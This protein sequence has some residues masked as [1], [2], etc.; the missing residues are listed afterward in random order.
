M[1]T[2]PWSRRG[3]LGAAVSATLLAPLLSAGPAHAA[4]E[5][6]DTL[7]L[8]WRE[9]LLG[10]GIDAVDPLFASRLT[11]LGT[12]AAGHRS[13]MAPSSA[14]LWPDLPYDSFS[15]DP[16]SST[17][18]RLK[19]MALAWSQPGT[20]LTGDASLAADIVAGLDHV[21]DNLYNASFTLPSVN[22]WWNAQIGSAQA[23]LDVC[24]LMYDKLSAAQIANYCA[25]IDHFLPESEL[26]PDSVHGATGAN[27]VDF[28]RVYALRGVVGKTPERITRARDALSVIFPYVTSGNGFYADGSF[29]EHS[30]IPYTGSYGAALISGMAWIFALLKGSTW[31]VTDAKKQLILDS[32]EDSFAPFL[33]NGVLMD[34]VSGR[35][36]S[37]GLSAT[38]TNGFASSDHVRGQSVMA[39]IL[40]LGMGASATE[41]ARWKG[42]VKGW[43]QRDYYLT[44]EQNSS[45][46][47][48]SFSRLRA[49]REDAAVA[50]VAEPTGHRLFA[51]MDRATHRRPGWAA[52][53]SMCSSD[54]AFYEFG[55]QENKRGWNTS[56]GMLY[57]WKDRTLGQFSDAFWPT[58]DPYRLPGT[59]VSRKALADGAGGDFGAPKPT[60]TWAG[61]ATDGTYAAIGMD[62]R[63]LQ[64][65]LGG[66]K[67]WFFLDDAIVCLGAGIGCTDGTGVESIVE[68]R[69]LGASGTHTLTVDGTAQ[70]ATQGWSATL[71]GAKWATLA[72]MGG[73]V[74][75]GG[76]TVK[77]QRAERT[78]AWSDVNGGGS[79]TAL[80]RRYLSLW[81]DHGTDP[82]GG[83]YA[84]I[85]MPGA[86]P[87]ATAARATDTNWL[88]V[89]A[90]S[91]NQQGIRVPSLGYTAVNFYGTGTVDKLISN[92]PASV[93]TR[94]SG[95]T[96]TLR[97]ANP[98]KTATS[99]DITWNRPVA[100]VLSKDPS[101]T[102]LSTGASLQLRIDTSAKTGATHTVT[103]TLA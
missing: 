15:G 77:A 22:W 32:V 9:L 82:S 91:G 40:M 58:V 8:R 74:F 61:G 57:W 71:T 59:T 35:A 88:T 47:L 97:V 78:G 3:F 39:A 79:T 20:G 60:S 67:S 44:L 29:V 96:A 25:A 19:T 6:Y 5:A 89:L 55:N 51:A 102:V 73:Y 14:A 84:Y 70:P 62:I 37:R 18:N 81:F 24:V 85:L 28:A 75:P 45:L 52:T 93:M 64:S 68:N 2:T 17:Y 33:Y 43:L 46:D 99:L 10:T 76:A 11:T 100:A 72:G 1:A 16:V 69:N 98:T 26:G 65:T 48:S 92:G 54:I 4:D 38:S 12:Q 7:R 66:R 50:A 63:G 23:L 101:V 83:K 21:H 27:R 31:D 80:T 90:N 53:L 86:E 49:V 87:D 56:S 42:M 41:Q 34:N 36:I 13:S 94:E 95:A 103:V 30:S